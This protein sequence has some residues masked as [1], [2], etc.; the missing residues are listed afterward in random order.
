LAG[1]VPL[2]P[3]GIIGYNRDGWGGKVIKQL[4]LLTLSENTVRGTG[5]LAEWGLS[6]LLE[7]DEGNILLDTG[8]GI[9]TVHNADA[10]GVDLTQIDKIVLSHGHP[11]HTGGLRELLKR[12]KKEIEII[13]HPDSLGPKYG[14][15]PERPDVFVGIPYRQEELESLGARFTL[16]ADSVT[17]SPNILTTGIV[18]MV[19]DFETVDPNLYTRVGTVLERDRLNDDQAIIIKTD[20][21]LVIVLGCAHRGL[22]NTVYRAQAL[23]G[24]KEVHTIVGGCHLI[25]APQTQ[26][27]RTIAAL[28]ELD[29]QKLGVSH[30]TGMPAAIAMANAFGN[31]F[32]FNNAGTITRIPEERK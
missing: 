11:D 10:M 19:T 30:C 15:N 29:F 32:F 3:A 25:R 12:R 17:L 22:V 13:A 1:N 8:A 5:L 27:E 16:R 7:T 14:R 6:I 28:K 31:R 20:F 9:S 21:G 18:P 2:P 26:I 24:I 23:T 4:R